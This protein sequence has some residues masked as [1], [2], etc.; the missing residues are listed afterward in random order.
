MMK[1]DEF[2]EFFLPSAFDL[3]LASLVTWIAENCCFIQEK[4]L[5]RGPQGFSTSSIF[6]VFR[7]IDVIP[8]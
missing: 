3:F 6:Q 5:W 1:N 2:V 7:S 8:L 4:R